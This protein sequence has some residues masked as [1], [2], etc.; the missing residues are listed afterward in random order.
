MDDMSR[1]HL[2][3]KDRW[4]S[5]RRFVQRLAH[6]CVTPC[7][8][9]NRAP[10]SLSSRLETAFPA[11][12]FCSSCHSCHQ[13]VV[14]TCIKSRKCETLSESDWQAFHCDCSIE[15]PCCLES[16]TLST[17]SL[18]VDPSDYTLSSFSLL[19]PLLEQHETSGGRYEE[20]QQKQPL[21]F[22]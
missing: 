2:L 18:F 16:G 6:K 12:H 15:H 11:R 22:Q 10:I 1:T 3:K 21:P 20:E 19:L 5:S 8:K 9:T 4:T 17:K 7:A 13:F 14:A